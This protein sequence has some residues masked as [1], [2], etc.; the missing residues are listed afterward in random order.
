MRR[1]TPDS[2]VLAS[3]QE[4]RPLPSVVTVDGLPMKENGLPGLGGGIWPSNQSRGYFELG[5]QARRH[6]ARKARLGAP[7]NE[8][9]RSAN[10]PSPAT[11]SGHG[12]NSLPFAIPLQT[13]PKVGRSLSHSQGQRE[14]PPSSTA[15]MQQAVAGMRRPSALPLGLLNKEAEEFDDGE[16]ERE[17]DLGG[18]LTQT[19]SHPV[20][21]NP[22]R[23][24]T[25]PTQ[26]PRYPD[27]F[28]GSLFDRRLE[29]V[30]SELSKR[31]FHFPFP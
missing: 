19:A 26:Y 28:N 6:A 5:E 13:T 10:T 30:L 21:G 12:A 3:Y 8:L 25:L 22:Q 9:A 1:A 27:T 20:F 24:S 4:K 31:T 11:S 15:S 7:T 14:M 29:A 23:I 16:S 2:E 17:S 18:L